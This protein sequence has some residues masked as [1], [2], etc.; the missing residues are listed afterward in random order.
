MLLLS[1]SL[2]STSLMMA[3]S[4]SYRCASSCSS[5]LSAEPLAKLLEDVPIPRIVLVPTLDAS[6]LME[7]PMPP[8]I[9]FVPTLVAKL[10]ELVPEGFIPRIVLVPTLDTSPER[11]PADCAKMSSVATEDSR[12]ALSNVLADGPLSD[13]R[14]CGGWFVYSPL[15]ASSFSSIN[16][17]A[18]D[19]FAASVPRVRPLDVLLPS[20]LIRLLRLC[21][22]SLKTAL[23]SSAAA[24][25]REEMPKS[26]PP[27]SDSRN[28]VDAHR[29]FR[30]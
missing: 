3:L 17:C 10:L 11:P 13:R 14:P 27:K 6:D 15:S 2:S 28:D 4:S 1:N 5:A 20:A 22:L 26:V 12:S 29:L 30:S 23:L 7:R 25:Q 19:L 24:P 18:A 9:V 8:M 16:V 21:S